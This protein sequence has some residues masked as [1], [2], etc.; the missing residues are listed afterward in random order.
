MLPNVLFRKCCTHRCGTS[1]FANIAGNLIHLISL[2]VIKF[3]NLP[4]VLVFR[5]VVKTTSIQSNFLAKL[6]YDPLLNICFY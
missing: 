2:K 6:K 1:Q 5:T 3:D 4:I